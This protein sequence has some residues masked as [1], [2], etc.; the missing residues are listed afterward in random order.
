[1]LSFLGFGSKKNEINKGESEK[2]ILARIAKEKRQMKSNN[3]YRKAVLAYHT[4]PEVLKE[5]N[6]SYAKK[7]G[8]LNKYNVGRVGP[9][10]HLPLAQ[11]KEL[12]AELKNLRAANLEEE[13]KQKAAEN[14]AEQA[15]INRL[16][17]EST[18]SDPRPPS[19]FQGGKQTR[20]RKQRKHRKVTRKH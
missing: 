13:L 1:M 10:S 5:N 9:Y 20:K 15:L 16:R 3:A 6:V 7:K 4:M 12:E 8:V 19:P 14:A 2:E 17:R 18:A 11:Y